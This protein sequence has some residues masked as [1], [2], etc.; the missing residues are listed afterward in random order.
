MADGIESFSE[1]RNLAR[2]ASGWKGGP[3][4]AKPNLAPPMYIKQGWPDTTLA[5]LDAGMVPQP[6]PIDGWN[7]RRAFGNK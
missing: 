4:L 2:V 7:Q 6:Q 3:F 5:K 1:S